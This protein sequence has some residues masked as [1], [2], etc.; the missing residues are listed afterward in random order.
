MSRSP[1]ALC[2][3]VT[4]MAVCGALLSGPLAAQERM[5]LGIG[6]MFTND[7]MGD[8]KDR[9]RTG[10]YQISVLRGPIWEGSLPARPGSLLEYRLRSEIIAPSE[11]S[12]PPAGDRRYAGVVSFGLHSHFAL[13]AAE[14]SAGLDLVALGPQTGVGEVHDWLHEQVSAP[15]VRVVED[16]IGNRL[17]PTLSGELGRSFALGSHAELR[18]FAEARLG[19]ETLV[20]IGADLSFGRIEHGALWSRDTVSGHRYVT[21]SGTSEPGA[22]FVLGGD[23]AYVAD[24][25]YLNGGSNDPEP[26]DSRL[27]L[28]AG[29]QIRSERM[30]L[31]YGATWLSEEFEGQPEGQ[32]LGSLRFRMNF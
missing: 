23:A 29:M 1:K 25:V 28:R 22:S 3:A 27:R 12:T 30:G 8:G 26:E 21:I 4:R 18:P 20:R 7:Y 32:V 15:S 14:A 31:F 5:T 16:E 2:S 13:G 10:S 19:D 24:S 6:R 11:L 17:V 9:W